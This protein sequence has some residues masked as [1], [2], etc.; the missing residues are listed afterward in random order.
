MDINLII[1]L[2]KKVINQDPIPLFKYRMALALP[3]E[4]RVRH[5]LSQLYLK[6]L[7]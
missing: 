5:L 1:W 7:I 6:T 2:S 4:V 3:R